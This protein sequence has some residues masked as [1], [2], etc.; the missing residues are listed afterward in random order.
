MAQK[1]SAE[2]RELLA[3]KLRVVE[4]HARRLSEHVSLFEAGIIRLRSLHNRAD[5]DTLT[6][7][8]FRRRSSPALSKT[9]GGWKLLLDSVVKA[10]TAEPSATAPGPGPENTKTTS[11]APMESH[12]RCADMQFA[13]EVYELGWEVRKAV[14]L[15]R[16][17]LIQHDLDQAE[18]ELGTD[19][20]KAKD[21][22]IDVI[23]MY[24]AIYILAERQVK[25]ACDFSLGIL[26]INGVLEATQAEIALVKLRLLATEKLRLKLTA[27]LNQ[28]AA[29]K[30]RKPRAKGGRP[31]EQERDKKLLEAWN[32]REYRNYAELGSAFELKAEAVRK[33]LKRA[34]AQEK[35][36]KPPHE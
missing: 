22:Y 17:S 25:E 32:T 1:K 9:T 3:S 11:A 12:L 20:A 5:F 13:K 15:G 10:T 19:H 31:S 6:K 2:D 23:A 33:A 26:A 24:H 35:N 27:T 4:E 28:D 7:E 29:T 14:P 16:V 21:E 18:I 34:K 8:L 30:Q 36:A